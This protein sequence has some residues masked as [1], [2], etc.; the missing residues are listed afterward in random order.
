[1]AKDIR[2]RPKI[3][4][5]LADNDEARAT[6]N[7]VRQWTKTKSGAPNIVRAI[8]M[9]AALLKGDTSLLIEYFPGLALTFGKSVSIARPRMVA[10]PVIS[11]E[12][13]SEE[14]DLADFADSLGADA[15][16]F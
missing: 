12:P 5:K 2:N 11:Y 13:K 4:Q 8:R 7:I 1:M 14:A 6:V 16:E 3:S 9:Y 15:L 10:E